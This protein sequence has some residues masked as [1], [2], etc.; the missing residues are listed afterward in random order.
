MVPLA[1]DVFWALMAIAMMGGLVA[2]TILTLT[3]LP[4]LYAMAFRVPGRAVGHGAEHSAMGADKAL[5]AA[6]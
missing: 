1:Q 2:A 3:F 4:A 6:T 5:V